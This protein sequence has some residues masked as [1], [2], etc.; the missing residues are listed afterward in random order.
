MMLYMPIIWLFYKENGLDLTDLFVIQSIYSITVAAIEIPSGYV[1]DALGRKNSM[2]IGTFFG[3]IG[4]IIYAF[5]FGFNG[6]LCAALS[7]GIGQSFIS[8]SDTA[9]MYDSLLEI[10]RRKDFIKLEGRTISMG[11]FAEAFAGF[12]G[13]YF[14]SQDTF[15]TPFYY[16]IG[17]ALIGFITAILLVEPSMAKLNEGKTKPWKNMKKILGFALVENSALRL[18]ILYSSIF[19]AATLTMAWFVQPLLDHLSIA[20]KYNGIIMGVLNLAVALT[21]FYAHR[22]ENQIHRKVMLTGILILLSGSYF[23]ISYN[24]YWWILIVVLVFYFT[25]GIATPVLRDYLNRLTPSEM[26]ATV[27]SIR[28][29]IVRGIFASSSPLLGYVA[30]VYSLQQALLFAGIL[31]LVIG[32]ITLIFTFN[33][34]VNSY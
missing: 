12:V 31:F 7:L 33:K 28:S 2:V 10:G 16:Q 23:V 27:M 17:I 20:G 1:G 32:S 15:R 18:Y 25:R 21:A 5:S 19:G 29:F 26:R 9:L 4:M 14:L 3:V 11:N 13:A 34:S 22:V 30:D 8:G 24:L 6:F